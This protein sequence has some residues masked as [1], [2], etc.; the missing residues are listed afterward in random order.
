MNSLKT[1]LAALALCLMGSTAFAGG[2]NAKALQTKEAVKQSI[3]ENIA[4]LDVVAMKIDDA[5]VSITFQV[6][7]QGKLILTEVDSNSEFAGA[8]VKQMLKDINMN[9]ESHLSN[10]A[11]KLSVRYVQI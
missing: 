2:G 8:Y 3:I 6:D 4:D 11:Y 10:K 1:G 9:V 5:T 7:S